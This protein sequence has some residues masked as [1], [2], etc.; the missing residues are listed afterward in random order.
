MAIPETLELIH[1]Q[2]GRSWYSSVVTNNSSN[3]RRQY[4][5][6]FH[7]LG[8]S[9]SEVMF[10]FLVKFVSFCFFILCCLV[11]LQPMRD[12]LVLFCRGLVLEGEGNC[13]K[14][15]LQPLEIP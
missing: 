8:I 2:R 1:S 10:F 5:G 12:F 11:F 6:K 3:S 14:L 9:V 15:V 7:S 4:A 13:S